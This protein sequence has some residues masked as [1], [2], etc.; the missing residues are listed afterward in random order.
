MKSVVLRKGIFALL[1][2]LLCATSVFAKTVTLSWDASPSDVAGYKVY[3]DTQ[4][5][6]TFAGIDAIEGDSP[7]DVGHV[8][9]YTVTGLYDDEDYYFAVTAYDASGNESIYSNTVVSNAVSAQNRAPVLSSIGAKTVSEGSTLAFPITASDADGDTLSYG[10]SN[11]PSDASFNSS[12]GSFSW[13]P[14]YTA[15]GTYSVIFSVSDGT[16]SA[17]ATVSITVNDVNRSP[18]LSN[19]GSQSVS[20][21]SSLSFTVSASDSDNDNLTFSAVNLPSGAS[22]DSSSRHFSWTPGNA[23]A[24]SYNVTF[25]VSDGQATDSEVVAISVGDVNQTPVLASVGSQS[26]NEGSSLSFNLSGSDAD[27]DALTYSATNLPPGASLSS[28]GAF[29]WTPNYSSAGSYDVT[30]SVSDGGAV[31]SEIVTVVVANVN[32]VPVLGS[33]GTKSVAEGSAL[34]FTLNASDSDGDNLTYSAS[35]L[36][37]GATFDAA[38]KTFSWTPAYAETENTRIYPVT[39]SVTD[40]RATDSE[41]VTINVTN[42][43]RAPVLDSI[44]AQHVLANNVFSLSVSATDPDNN[45]LSYSVADLP[46]GATFDVSTQA[47]IWAPTVEQVGTY[48][49]VFSV[50][51]GSLSASEAVTF[52]VTFNNSAPVISGTP[53][54]SIMA[55]Y[56][57]AFTPTASDV[58]GDDLTFSINNKPSWASFDASSGRLYGSPAETQTGSYSD[59]VISVSDGE[60]TSS[61]A[62]FAISVSAY[63]PIDTDLDG[64][65]DSEDAFPNDRSEW[66]DTDGDNIGNIADTDDDNDGVEDQYDGAPLDSTKSAWTVYAVAEEG[67][68]ITPEGDTYLAYGSGQIF[69]L[70]PQAGY[71]ISNL[72]VNGESV[73]AVTSYAITS[74]TQH[75]E[76]IAEFEEIPVGLSIDNIVAGLPGVERVDGGDDSNNYVDGVPKLALDYEFAVTFRAGDVTANTR[77]IYLVLN[78]YKYAM[79]L[80]NGSLATGAEYTLTTRLGPAY[81]HNFYFVAEDLSGNELSR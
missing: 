60:L 62:P 52:T 31:D 24:G 58:N 6:G 64:I 44:G 54:R 13:T 40:G 26:V 18:V 67:G 37:S 9:T 56:Y 75:I 14:D 47:F 2:T 65:P 27:G 53:D 46:S 17:M 59:I 3:Y 36:P 77:I 11:L 66:Q 50:S 7:V 55:T 28:A 74:I 79:S 8:L 23:A 25:T 61:L 35:D 21:G 68:Y 49:V 16:D 5:D 81:A 78:G 45:T 29:N 15:E 70:M 41:T 43:N 4:A 39:F 12:T 38:A 51:D 42:V 30:F 1:L 76:L 80:S 57:Y 63:V 34:T 72:W 48:Q 10:A 71:Y 19:I 33:I 73:G 69:E 22:F 20:E 32:Q